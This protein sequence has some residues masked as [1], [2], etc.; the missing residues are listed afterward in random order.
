MSN[1]RFRTSNYGSMRRRWE[2]ENDELSNEEC[3]VFDEYVASTDENYDDDDDDDT[4]NPVMT[5]DAVDKLF[6]DIGLGEDA[7][8]G[9]EKTLVLLDFNGLLVHRYKQGDDVQCLPRGHRADWR[10]RFGKFWLRPHVR[11]FIEHLLNDPR[12]DVAIYTSMK[13]RNMSEIVHQWDQH[14]LDKQRRGE[15]SDMIVRIH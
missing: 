1:R 7:I 13:A 6:N 11:E 12:C 10:V 4:N 15:L 3:D 8:L 14:F 2:L 9:I 5:S